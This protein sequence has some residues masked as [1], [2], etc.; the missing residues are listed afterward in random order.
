MKEVG[1]AV[2]KNTQTRFVRITYYIYYIHPYACFL[3]SSHAHT[4]Y[5]WGTC[6]HAGMENQYCIPMD[7]Y[8]NNY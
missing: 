8:Q 3:I 7:Q 5:I 4:Y 1:M 2:P 6:M